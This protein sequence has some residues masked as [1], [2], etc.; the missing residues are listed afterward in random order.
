[1]RAAVRTLFCLGGSIG[2]AGTPADFLR[3]LP[4]YERR[5]TRRSGLRRQAV[6]VVVECAQV[7]GAHPPERHPR[8]RRSLIVVAAALKA[9]L[10][11][12]DPA[13]VKKAVETLQIAESFQ[14]QHRVQAEAFKDTGYDVQKWPGLKVQL[15]APVCSAP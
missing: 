2:D 5:L 8:H 9:S 1:M 10:L 6:Q 7:F 3:F 14:N 11:S 15:S 12:S 13:K 4:L